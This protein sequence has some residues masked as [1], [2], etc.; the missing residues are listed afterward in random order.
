MSH[1]PLHLHLSRLPRNTSIALLASGGVDSSVALHM[2]V[3]AGFSPDLYY[4]R[5]GMEDEEGA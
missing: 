4:I 2:L 3:E 1:F 5:I